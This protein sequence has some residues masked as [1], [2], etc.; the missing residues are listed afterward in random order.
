MFGNNDNKSN[1]D[2]NSINNFI[3]Q[4]NKPKPKTTKSLFSKKLIEQKP[5]EEQEHNQRVSFKPKTHKSLKSLFYPK[6]SLSEL[7]LNKDFEPVSE[8]NI[9]IDIVNSPDE[10]VTDLFENLLLN[11]NFNKECKDANEDQVNYDTCESDRSNSSKSN[12]SNK[13]DKSDCYIDL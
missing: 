5:V 12:K 7:N 10:K 11:C 13:S 3:R 6:F 2:S 4:I 8:E 1:K 9:Q